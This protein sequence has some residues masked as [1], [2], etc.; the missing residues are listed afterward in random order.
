MKNPTCS[1]LRV[2]ALPLLIVSGNTE[3]PLRNSYPLLMFTVQIV[4]ENLLVKRCLWPCKLTF[5]CWHVNHN[6]D[7][8]VFTVLYLVR[9]F[10]V[11]HDLVCWAVRLVKPLSFQ[12]N[13]LAPHCLSNVCFVNS[14]LDLHWI[15]FLLP[16]V[17]TWGICF[18]S[19]LLISQ[20]T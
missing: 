17:F 19:H 16:Q 13:F 12:D 8:I 4:Y 6:V 2:K 1:S 15:F 18:L 5:I 14:T 11:L 10:I 7:L 9:L 3:N 20:L